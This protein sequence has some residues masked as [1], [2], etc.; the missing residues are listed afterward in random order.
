MP[1]GNCFRHQDY[2]AT[3]PASP[4]HLVSP[5][6]DLPVGSLDFTARMQAVGNVFRQAGVTAIY[7]VHGTFVGPDTV[8]FLQELRRIFPRAGPM[9]TRITKR[10]IDT[11]TGDAGNYTGRFA[12]TFEDAIHLP[13]TR[14]ISVRRFHWSGQNNHIGRAD[15]AVR[16]IEEL[17]SLGREPGQRAL[18]WGHSHAGNVFAL[19]SNLLAADHETLDK[20]FQAAR[21][22]Y[23]WPLLG[24]I[25]IPVW[26]RARLHLSGRVH[27]LAN[28]RLDLVTFGTP[29]RYGWDSDG[30]SRLLHFVNHRPSEGLPRYRAPF[31]PSVDRVLAASDGDYVQQIGIAGTNVMP[32]P[33]TWRSWLA[34]QRLGALL[35]PPLPRR[36]LMRRLRAGNRVAAEGT[37]LLVDYGPAEGTIG[38]HVAGHAVYTRHKWLL[39][40]AEEVAKRFYHAVPCRQPATA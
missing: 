34:D 1:V 6:A 32:S 7:L 29:I 28:L 33:F 22:Y 38:Q 13:G 3:F 9:V 24:C 14:R 27:P 12:Q 20:F 37:T 40:H 10:F 30:Y 36:K 2:R 25:D 4:Y 17:A 21:I 26:R 15:A 11:M 16:L 31:P 18:L 5:P 8:G 19:M 23:R 39:F 35:Q